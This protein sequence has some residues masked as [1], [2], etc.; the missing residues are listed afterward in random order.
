MKKIR[1]YLRTNDDHQMI[2]RLATF[3]K[4]FSERFLTTPKVLWETLKYMEETEYVERETTVYAD[5]TQVLTFWRI[6]DPENK[7]LWR[8]R[9]PENKPRPPSREPDF[10]QKMPKSVSASETMTM[11]NTEDRKRAGG[12]VHSKEPGVYILKQQLTE[13]PKPQR[14]GKKTLREEARRILK[15]E[16]RRTKN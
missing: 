11:I 3:G 2:W 4:H 13:V 10:E 14:S 7:L 15:G 9:H 8:I 16:R 12:L 5:G 6:R 1:S